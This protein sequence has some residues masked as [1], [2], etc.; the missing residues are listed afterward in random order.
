MKNYFLSIALALGNGIS[1]VAETAPGEWRKAVKAPPVH[2]VLSLVGALQ[3]KG[4]L[5]SWYR[6]EPPG[7]PPAISID[8]DQF[9]TLEEAIRKDKDIGS[10]IGFSA[11]IAGNRIWVWS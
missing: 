1:L 11:G 2:D 5:V 9:K 8:L 4:A 6:N 3:T 7:K 10:K